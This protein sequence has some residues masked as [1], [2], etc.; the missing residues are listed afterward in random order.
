MWHDGCIEVF[1]FACAAML[2]FKPLGVSPYCH[3]A[4]LYTTAIEYPP[5]AVVKYTA[6]AVEVYP[7]YL[8]VHMNVYPYYVY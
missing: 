2:N 8:Y 3:P 5:P 1:F 7:T 6:Y 4:Q